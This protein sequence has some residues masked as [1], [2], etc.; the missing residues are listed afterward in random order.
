MDKLAKEYEKFDETREICQKTPR[1][2]KEVALDARHQKLF[3]AHTDE[4]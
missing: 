1:K 2:F 4:D 3:P